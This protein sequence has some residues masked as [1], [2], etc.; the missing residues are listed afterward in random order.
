M[1]ADDMV[2]FACADPRTSWLYSDK[3]G[4]S[5]M[6]VAISRRGFTV[7]G[8]CVSPAAAEGTAIQAG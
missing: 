5:P 1:I 7:K 3:A 8:H 4:R 6:K 2:T